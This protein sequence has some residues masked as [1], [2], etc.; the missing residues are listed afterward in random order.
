MLN[1]FKYQ[2]EIN[3]IHS[4]VLFSTLYVEMLYLSRC[5][6]TKITATKIEAVFDRQHVFVSLNC[7]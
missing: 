6:I 3:L 2:L 5:R 7:I 4:I 1:E